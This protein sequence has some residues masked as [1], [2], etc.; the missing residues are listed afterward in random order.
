MEIMIVTIPLRDVPQNGVPYGA[1]TIMNYVRKRGYDDIEFYHIDD[2]RPAFE[3][4]IAH[5]NK[6]KPDILGISAIVSTAYD[7]TKRLSTNVKAL[8][9][10]TLIVVGGN[11]AASAEIL[12]RKTGTDLIVIGEGEKS[13]LDILRHSETTH[14][15]TDFADIKGL[16]LIDDNDRFINTG[17]NAPLPPDQIWDVDFRDLERAT[18]ISKIFY[19]VYNKDGPVMQWIANDP[20]SFEPHRRNKTIGHIACV[21]GCV[22]RCTFCHRWDKGIKHISVERIMTELDHHIKNYNTGFVQI[23]AE[24]F[25][26]DK[27]WLKE[28]CEEIKKRDVLWWSGGL[29]ANAAAATPEWIEIMKDSGCACLTYGNETGSEKM[30]Q[31]M[32]KKVSIED[33]YNSMKWT[34]GAGIY[35]GIQLVI[36]MPGE[37]N[38]TI[39]ETIEYCKFVT[40]LSPEKD[41]S[42]MS[43]NFAQALPGTPLY[44]FARHRGLIGQ[45]MDGEEEYLLAI[46][47]RNARD[48]TTTLNFTEESMLRLRTWRPKI[49]IE[50]N[51]NFVKTFGIEQYSKV[52][53]TEKVFLKLVDAMAGVSMRIESKGGPK[54]PRL[55]RLL[56]KSYFGMAMLCYPVFFHRIR[57]LMPVMVLVLTMRNEGFGRAWSLLKD[58]LRHTLSGGRALRKFSFDYKSLWKIV[59]KDLG[60]LASDSPDMQLFR[61]GR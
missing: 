34:I 1:L 9:P 37:T 59:S 27:K 31:I 41:P 5:I 4:V 8:L 24:T 50:V 3:D 51:Y 60:V 43:S 49:T 56:M 44:E 12:L 14:N 23:F 36:G 7:Y 47:D 61:D 25:G 20:R 19:K 13:F 21:K 55:A 39:N 57:C 42:Y 17:I 45:D 18:D 52:V 16:A 40:T 35:T 53:F 46:S 22:A 33:N 2:K 32:E 10:D 28:F 54:P 26:N 29:R 15:P 58:H 38:E 6:E 11:M 48:E 30:L